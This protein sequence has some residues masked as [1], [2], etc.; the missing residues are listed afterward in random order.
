MAMGNVRS[1]KALVS[2]KPRNN[3]SAHTLL[4]DT[5]QYGFPVTQPQAGRMAFFL[6]I[7]PQRQ[8]LK[9]RRH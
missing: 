5:K 4:I 9:V 3:F 6:G 2:R 7:H 8:D 1:R